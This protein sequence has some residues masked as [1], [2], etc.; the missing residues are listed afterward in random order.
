M[1]T[2]A[3]TKKMRKIKTSKIV[4]GKA[5]YSCLILAADAAGKKI[6][7]AEGLGTPD[8]MNAVQQAFCEKDALMCGFCTPGY[9]TAI[10]SY[11]QLHP[12]KTPTKDEIR[13]ACKGNFCRC[14]T[15]PRIFEAALAAAEA[16]AKA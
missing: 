13:E 12:E 15:Y 10:S 7:T 14:G 8:K 1:Q 6:V 2:T 16:G 3:T 9:V 5:V 11:L 4:D